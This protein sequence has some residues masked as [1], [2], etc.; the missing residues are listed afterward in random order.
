VI[1]T[2][3]EYLIRE[4][5]Y[6]LILR[7][8]C[9]YFSADSKEKEMKKIL[10]FLLTFLL[11]SISISSLD[12]S[13]EY[14][15]AVSKRTSSERI[16][17]LED[18][19]KKFNDSKFHKYVYANLALDYNQ[20]GK[21]KDAI[22]NGEKAL[23]Y[24]DLE[25]DWRIQIFLVLAN[26]YA[27]DAQKKDLNK[28]LRYV[29]MALS[30]SKS[31]GFTTLA[32]AANNAKNI[33]DRMISKNDIV[34]IKSLFKN[35]Q[36]KELVAHVNKMDESAKNNFDV[37]RYYALSLYQTKKIDDA[38]RAFEKAYSRKKTGEIS[39][40]IA[41]ILYSKSK[42]EKNLLD[43]SVE[44]FIRAGYLFSKEKNQ[45]MSETA[46]A[47][48]QHLFF[49]EKHGLD[50]IH[51]EIQGKYS[52]FDNEYSNLV[53]EYNA[54]VKKYEGRT[55]TEE[56]EEKIELM[57]KRIKELESLL[58]KKEKEIEKLDVEKR[59]FE[60]EFQNLLSSFKN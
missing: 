46:I 38:L 1:E 11:Y 36:F 26:S 57:E 52:K 21:F 32:N 41:I 20:I 35:N 15:A 6:Y 39:N 45:R 28:A 4:S 16:T 12:Q 49:N 2:N 51:K 34:Q 17:A 58:E 47:R 42:K 27:S 14:A 13:D 33:I 18:Y 56:D 24:K 9:F 19:L 37:L 44:Y 54:L 60:I 50:N 30:L 8:L 43:T 3:A 22:N 5:S 10:I 7:E 53:N 23:E 25:A 59:K 29:D 40:F 48:A 31:Q 55:I